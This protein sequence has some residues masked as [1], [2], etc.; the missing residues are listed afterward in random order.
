MSLELLL[1]Y[2]MYTP[3]KASGA[4]H[5]RGDGFALGGVFQVAHGN[6]VSYDTSPILAWS[7]RGRKVEIVT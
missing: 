4:C 1:L 3:L 5:D 2:Y 7:L 6:W